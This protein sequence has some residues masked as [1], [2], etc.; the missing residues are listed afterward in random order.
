M[1]EKKPSPKS[2]VSRYL[3]DL[4]PYLENKEQDSAPSDVKTLTKQNENFQ[5]QSEEKAAKEKMDKQE[6]GGFENR[7]EPT[8]FGDWEV[9]G[10][11]SDF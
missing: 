3:T 1:T 2:D 8:R 9:A 10:R 6:K 4:T 5:E 7:A 11:C